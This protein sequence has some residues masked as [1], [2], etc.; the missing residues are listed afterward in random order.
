MQNNEEL[1]NHLIFIEA[2]TDAIGDSTDLSME[3]IREELK[4][5]GIDLDESVRNLISFIDVC[6]MDAK[7]EELDRA[8]EAMKVEELKNDKLKNKNS[9]LSKDEL[10][11]RIKRLIDTPKAQ[12][13][14][15]Y[16]RLEGKT[17]EDLISILEDLEAAKDFEDE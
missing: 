7:R 5:D 2:F 12:I 9:A 3:E 6:V 17:E 13:S 11:E 8:A 15:A 1:K 14:F 4:R 10:L 16:R